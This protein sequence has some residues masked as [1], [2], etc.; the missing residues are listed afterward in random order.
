M[1]DPKDAAEYFKVRPG[2][3]S[4]TDAERADLAARVPAAVQFT[5][6]GNKKL[7]ITGMPCAVPGQLNLLLQDEDPA[8][9]KY[10]VPGYSKP[11]PSG[12]LRSLA[13]NPD[14]PVSPLN[15]PPTLDF[16]G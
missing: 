11:R 2:S 16:K 1:N 6:E 14:I 8:N 7:I 4:L 10:V 3:S 15:P 9:R 5:P 12:Y 13:N